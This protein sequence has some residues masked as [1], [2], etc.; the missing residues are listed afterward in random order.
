MKKYKLLWSA[1]EKI[2]SGSISIK[3]PNGDIK[4]FESNKEG[5]KADLVIKNLAAL[6]MSIH[7][8][9]VGFGESYMQD[10][11][12]SEDLPTLL[13]FFLIMQKL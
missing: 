6:N 3:L 11:W 9:D 12:D 13:S 5:P 8:G 1:F 4:K 10:M 7:G 2:E